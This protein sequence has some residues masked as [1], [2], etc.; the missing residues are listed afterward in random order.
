MLCQYGKSVN[1]DDATAMMWCLKAVEQGSRNAQFNHRWMYQTRGYKSIGKE[2]QSN[3]T[4]RC[5]C[6]YY[7]GWMYQYGLDKT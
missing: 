3:R 2:S 4:G 7:R 1:K 5:R 6:G